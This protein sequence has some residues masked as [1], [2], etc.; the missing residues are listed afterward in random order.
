MRKHNRLLAPLINFEEIVYKIIQL[1]QIKL[2][3][4]VMFLQNTV[5]K[6]KLIFF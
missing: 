4:Y 6:T 3:P 1:M 2:I 5:L